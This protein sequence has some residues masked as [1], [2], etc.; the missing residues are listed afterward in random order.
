[1]L[2]LAQ[3][4]GNSPLHPCAPCPCMQRVPLAP[5]PTSSSSPRKR[6]FE[7][8]SHL[9]GEPTWNS[10]MQPITSRGSHSI[11][12]RCPRCATPQQHPWSSA[13]ERSG[14]EAAWAGRRGM[15]GGLMQGAAHT[16]PIA[17]GRPA[18]GTCP[19]HSR[20]A[21]TWRQ[22]LLHATHTP[23]AKHNE[24]CMQHEPRLP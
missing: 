4:A 8:G 14:K 13:W 12:P 17:S 3:G 23:L 21:R 2:C 6:D 24:S 1:M 11:C 15:R 20:L 9:V 10:G 5:P 16:W 19:A 18:A 22:R 7:P